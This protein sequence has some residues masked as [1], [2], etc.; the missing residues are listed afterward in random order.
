MPALVLLLACCYCLPKAGAVGQES[1]VAAAS[2][3]GDFPLVVKQQAAPIF[4]DSKDFRGVIRAAGD[5]QSD[6]QRVTGLKPGLAEDASHL[7]PCFILIGTL[8]KSELLDE[9]VRT[10]KIDVSAIAGKWESFLLQVVA[11]PLPGVDSALVITGSDKRGTIYGIYDLSAQIGVS[12]WTWWA[13]VPVPRRD[14]LY[15]LPGRHSEGPPAVKYRGFFINDEAPALSGWARQTF[16]GFNHQFYEHVFE[17]LLRMKADFLWPAMWGNAFNEDD[18]LNNRLADVY[19][20][21]MST[22]HHEPMMRAQQEWRR[23]GTGPWNY[24]SNADTLRAFWRQGIVNM[25]SHESIVTVGMRGD[26]DMPMSQQSNIALL[27][28][29]VADQRRIIADVTGRGPAALPQVWALYKEVQDYY[30]RGMRVPDDVTLLFS[31]D[32][33][34]DIRRLPDPGAARRSG[35]YGLYYHFDYV[36]GPRNYKWINTNLVPRVWEQLHLAWQS[37]V[38]RIWVVNVGDIK[39]MELPT[40]FFLD[41]AWDPARWPLE[42]LPEYTRLWAA[43][44]FGAEH[45]AEIAALLE[46][47]TRFNARRKPELLAPET[48][49]LTDYGEADSVVAQYERL[50][51]EAQR[52]WGILPA[53]DRDA[54][55]E[56]VLHPILASANLNDLY[57]TAARNRLYAAQGRAATNALAARVRQLFARDSEITRYYNDTLAGGRW[58]HMM[59]QT[60]I[61]YRYWQE[62]RQNGMPEVREV[63]LP[64][65]A[66][67]GVAIE[68]SSR[69]WPLAPGTTDT[70]TPVLPALDPH[71]APH[72]YFDVFNRGGAPFE[73][74]AH[75]D[76][77]WLTVTPSRARVE[78]EQ[79]VW[80]SVDWRR[81]PAGSRLA[82]ITVSGPRVPV[83]IRA[84]VVQPSAPQAD[85]AQG[86]LESRGYVSIEAEHYSRAVNAGDIRWVRIPGLGRTLSGVTT[87][88]VTAPRQTPGGDAPHLE[89]H[90]YL[91]EAGEFAVRAFFSPALDVHATG[92]RYAVSFDGEAPQVVNIAADTTLRAWER[93]VADNA[94][95]AVTRHTLDRLGEH[96]LRIWMVDPGVVLQKLVVEH[97]FAPPP[98]SYLGPPESFHRR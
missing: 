53:A 64:A 49:S 56:L 11:H 74:R 61:G 35:G 15:V 66:D 63:T 68:G 24:E 39:P 43:Q 17:L 23:H 60:H 87:F 97:A 7:P 70:A 10:H 83:V 67:M 26:G 82:A 71:G 13:D 51:E 58:P 30:D 81:A 91:F 98:P 57:V 42:R 33:W 40:Q 18:T 4:V 62:P 93:M 38:D 78:T 77:P 5:L 69:S 47:Y 31:D 46:G 48:Y 54:F 90:L 72:A 80:V 95:V 16:G 27:E 9:L 50:A 84:P 25:G 94:A 55:Y 75:A 79:R 37:G 85:S 2:A 12:P 96:V 73:F 21:V 76:A 14:A 52:L 6:L 29:I 36:G 1:Y 92:V 8:G 88:P 28:R 45:A 89:Y 32:N 44:Q 86:F 19:G 59:D 3:P 22:S 65:A 20:I 34:G 41:Y